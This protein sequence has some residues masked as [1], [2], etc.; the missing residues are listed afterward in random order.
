M[1]L[2]HMPW[3]WLILV[4]AVCVIRP[5][6]V[7]AAEGPT[8]NRKQIR[9]FLL[10]AEVMSS[11]RDP[12]GIAHP[13]RL[14]L[15]NG[16]VTHDASFQSRDENNKSYRYNIAAS[17]LAE[18]L[19]LED[20]LPVYVEREWHG[21]W[22]SFSWWLPMQMDEEER[23]KRKVE[24]PDLEAWNKQIDNMRV[25][26]ALVDESETHPKDLLI[27]NDWKIYRVDYSRGFLLDRD[28]QNPKSLIRCDRNLLQRL[29]D[30]NGRQLEQKTRGY[31]TKSEVQALMARRDKILAYFNNLILEKGENAVLF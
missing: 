17:E 14:T 21:K 2:P 20:T 22:G 6:L 12:R 28:L 24:P 3:H 9:Q 16:T 1:R 27:G 13:W 19:G 26:D 29:K 10:N 4:I 23:L 15:S 8:L 11:Q 5:L 25:F 18:M 30:L 7:D 31:L